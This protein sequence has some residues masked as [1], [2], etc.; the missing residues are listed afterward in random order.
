MNFIWPRET[1]T[2]QDE[3]KNIQPV[4]LG[5]MSIAGEGNIPSL[6]P[7]MPS[8]AMLSWLL[9]M[10]VGLRSGIFP[11]PSGGWLECNRTGPKTLGLAGPLG[12]QGQI[13]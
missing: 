2:C 3:P 6:W 11:S 8:V 1:L 12:P 7:P 13:C 5:C 10:A 4:P 9:E